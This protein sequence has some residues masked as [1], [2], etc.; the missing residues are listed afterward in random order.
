MKIKLSYTGYLKFDGVESDP[1]VYS[2]WVE[3]DE[4]MM[5]HE[6]FFEPDTLIFHSVGPPP[7]DDLMSGSWKPLGNAWYVLQ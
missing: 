7:A 2:L 3:M 4:N 5:P 1:G 6:F